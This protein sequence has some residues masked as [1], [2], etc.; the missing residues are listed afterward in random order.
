MLSPLEA[1]KTFL[2]SFPAYPDVVTLVTACQS[3]VTASAATSRN[4]NSGRAFQHSKTHVGQRPPPADSQEELKERCRSFAPAPETPMC[5]R[6][7]PLLQL[8]KQARAHVQGIFARAS[9]PARFEGAWTPHEVPGV[10]VPT[11]TM[12]LA[13]GVPGNGKNVVEPFQ[14]TPRASP[15]ALLSGESFFQQPE[16]CRTSLEGNVSTSASANASQLCGVLEEGTPL[17]MRAAGSTPVVGILPNRAQAE[18]PFTEQPR[19]HSTPVEHEPG[20][21]QLRYQQWQGSRHVTPTSCKVADSPFRIGQ[22]D[23][24]GLNPMPR[25]FRTPFTRASVEE[26]PAHRQAFESMTPPLRLAKSLIHPPVSADMQVARDQASKCFLRPSSS[27]AT[28]EYDSAG[29]CHS[30][31]AIEAKVTS[32][33]S[34]EFPHEQALRGLEGQ[35]TAQPARMVAR[36]NS[37]KE[38]KECRPELNQDITCTLACIPH[39]S[40][41]RGGLSSVAVPAA[42]ANNTLKDPGFAPGSAFVFTATRDGEGEC[43]KRKDV[44]TSGTRSRSRP[45]AT[46]RSGLAHPR[47]TERD[48]GNEADVEPPPGV[49]PSV[50]TS[51]AVQWKLGSRAG[52][53]SH[54][55]HDTRGD[56]LRCRVSGD[57]RSSSAVPRS[58]LHVHGGPIAMQSPAT[59]AEP[60]QAVQAWRLLENGRPGKPDHVAVTPE[61]IQAAVANYLKSRLPASAARLQQYDQQWAAFEDGTSLEDV[62]NSYEQTSSGRDTQYLASG[63]AG[64]RDT[65]YLVA[66]AAG[67][68]GLQPVGEIPRTVIPQFQATSDAQLE[69]DLGTSW[70]RWL[71]QGLQLPAGGGEIRKGHP[72]EFVDFGVLQGDCEG[73]QHVGGLP[74]TSF[75]RPVGTI[76]GDL[77]E[78]RGPF[79]AFPGSRSFGHEGH[80]GLPRP[81]TKLALCGRLP[82][83]ELRRFSLPS[84]PLSLDAIRHMLPQAATHVDPSAPLLA[85]RTTTVQEMTMGLTYSPTATIGLAPSAGNGE[86]KSAATA[87]TACGLVTTAGLLSAGHPTPEPAQEQACMERSHSRA[88]QGLHDVQSMESYSFTA[89]TMAAGLQTH[90]IV[91][92]QNCSGRREL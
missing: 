46:P 35:K 14:A 89:E 58:G 44:S 57:R 8:R 39:L 2:A 49:A 15:F 72:G 7:P 84:R 78:G 34:G 54:G 24:A 37:G 11:E 80:V 36:E 18:S 61:S 22:V 68:L 42:R 66:S 88:L 29:P 62:T 76:Q 19:S 50:F 12:S 64:T 71:P 79:G 48:A 25:N 87:H 92:L 70:D 28:S 20:N 27:A 65:Q 41:P 51:T 31:W 60:K 43:Q 52:P 26:E 86:A 82:S 16:G 38:V 77:Q 90:A 67:T 56:P 1:A 83:G 73:S 74:G 45:A 30:V 21:L 75:T 81:P 9:G 5:T 40:D 23:L 3:P 32:A 53:E 63:M 91:G 59:V 10:P 4:V 47:G 6:P 85:V 13:P 69:G 33:Q 55:H 17:P